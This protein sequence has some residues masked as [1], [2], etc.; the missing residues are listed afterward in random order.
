MCRVG[1]F[2]FFFFQFVD[3]PPPPKKKNTVFFLPEARVATRWT[4]NNP[5]FLRVALLYILISVYYSCH[6]ALL[7]RVHLVRGVGGWGGAVVR[8]G[9][10]GR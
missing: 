10:G 4:G 5:Y 7:S 9:G 3:S 8:G 1:T 2:F 6:P